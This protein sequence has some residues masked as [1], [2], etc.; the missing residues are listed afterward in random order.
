MAM[1][2]PM[3]QEDVKAVEE[4]SGVEKISGLGKSKGEMTFPERRAKAAKMAMAKE[5]GRGIPKRWKG[6]GDYYFEQL[7]D[8]GLKITGG[9]SAKSLTGGKSTV[10]RD[11]SEIRRIFDVARKGDIVEE[12]AVYQKVEMDEEAPQ[13][14][15][16][17]AQRRAN[18]MGPEGTKQMEDYQEKVSLGETELMEGEGSVQESPMKMDEGLDLG[19][20]ESDEFVM[21]LREMGYSDEMIESIPERLRDQFLRLAKRYKK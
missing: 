6:R 8:G 11:P 10:I 15:Q 16:A 20:S 3:M 14:L 13:M 2:E 21:A 19:E 7:D 18:V 4:T 9:D 12:G 5:V 1:Q 17:D